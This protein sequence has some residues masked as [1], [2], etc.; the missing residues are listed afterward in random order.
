MKLYH[1]LHSLPIF[2]HVMVM[3]SKQKLTFHFSLR[4]IIRAQIPSVHQESVVC[5]K[6]HLYRVSDTFLCSKDRH[7]ALNST[8]HWLTLINTGTPPWERYTEA[9]RVRLRAVFKI[10][11]LI[12]ICVP[13]K[14]GIVKE[15]YKGSVEDKRKKNGNIALVI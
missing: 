8:L 4:K 15:R 3:I 14:L 2:M 11:D 13:V 5:M 7:E 12:R 1:L 10:I 9:I 6:N